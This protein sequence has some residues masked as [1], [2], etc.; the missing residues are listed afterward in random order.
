MEIR[1][2]S[3]SEQTPLISGAI[4]FDTQLQPA[5]FDVTVQR[6]VRVSGRGRMNTDFS[7]ELPAEEEISMRDGVYHLTSGPY[8]FYLN[9]IIAL[10]L[11]IAGLVVPRS[12]L[13][14]CGAILSSGLWDP[15]FHGRGRLGISV[16]N[17]SGI[18]IEGNAPLAQ[19]I[20]FKNDEAAQGFRWN[21]YYER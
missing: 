15:G 14:R 21:A 10:P 13:I 4:D 1:K 2:L 6:I 9:E 12:S 11:N 19:M 3:H 16:V 20:F 17:E 7:S 8:L 18:L 5:G